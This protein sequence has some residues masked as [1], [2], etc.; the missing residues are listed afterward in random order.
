MKY[1]QFG[2]Y[3]IQDFNENMKKKNG[4]YRIFDF[5]EKKINI[6]YPLS[7]KGATNIEVCERK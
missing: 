3:S 6:P 7:Q 4:K 5:N 1:D 2:Q